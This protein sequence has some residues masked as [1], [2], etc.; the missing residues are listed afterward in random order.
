MAPSSLRRPL[1]VRRYFFIM[2]SPMSQTP[3]SDPYSSGKAGMGGSGSYA[4][5]GGPPPRKSRTGLWVGIG[6]GSVCLLGCLCL[7]PLVL[8]IPG[9]NV[10]R[11]AANRAS[12]SNKLKQLAIGM[13]IY[14]DS[15]GRLPALATGPSTSA[16]DDQ[17][18]GRLSWAV[19]ILPQIERANVYGSID[20]DNAPLPEDP[21]YTSIGG[22]GLANSFSCP[23]DPSTTANPTG[24]SYRV[25]LGQFVINNNL[26]VSED[27][28]GDPAFRNT[29]GMFA[30]GTGIPFAQVL[31]GTSNTFLL[32][33]AVIDGDT[34]DVR[35]RV[36]WNL[37]PASDWEA[38]S[39]IVQATTTSNAG[40]QYTDTASLNPVGSGPGTRWADGAPYYSG[41]T[42]VL[43]PNLASG[44]S[45]NDLSWGLVT[46][47]S[48]HS[49]GAN[50]ALVDS[51]VRFVPNSVDL[52]ALRA[53]G[54][55]A[56]GEAY[57]L[58]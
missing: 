53:A 28:M 41:F 4:P 50:F 49:G 21:F 20:F 10:A 30:R 36:A 54:T 19:A 15:Y 42:T 55:R 46:P 13:H 32:S 33:E 48:R 5:Q 45:G 38:F 18:V 43:T 3:F 17:A 34:T 11:E 16:G 57:P 8:L 9:I 14:A 24:R 1:R 44:L 29:T 26:P 23:S 35:G 37:G 56:G 25:N 52:L 40:R 47:T 27:Q 7:G 6:L 58:P 51:S 31:D 2:S 12:C 39:N 22:P